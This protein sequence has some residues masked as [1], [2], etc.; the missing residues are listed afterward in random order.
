LLI[1]VDMLYYDR[2]IAI[3][4]CMKRKIISLSGN[5]DILM[6]DQA[7]SYIQRNILSGSMKAGKAV[8]EMTIAKE[9]GIS[10]TP[11]R[12]ALGQLVAEGLL[13]Q[14]PNRG[15]V[16]VQ[17]GR[18]DIIHLFELREALEAFAVEKVARTRI[19]PA[20]LD[21]LQSLADE[22]LSLKKDLDRSGREA[23]NSSQRQQFV[24]SDMGFHALLIQLAENPRISKVVSSTRLL[25]RFFATRSLPKAAE[26]EWIYN[27]HAE[28][29]QAVASQDPERAVRII[30]KH[31]QTSF[32]D[33]LDEFDYWQRE[34]LL[35]DHYP[36]FVGDEIG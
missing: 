1:D 30:R 8:S 13:E 18:L 16:V 10:R 5:H 15:A 17:F 31:I 11:I 35:D 36:V 9:L 26:L 22:I 23:L 20:N 27:D 25:I 12:E 2:N 34:S 29:L 32:K 4:S 14:I 33:R 7:Y 28:V 19:H 21:R 24:R 3:L 6:R